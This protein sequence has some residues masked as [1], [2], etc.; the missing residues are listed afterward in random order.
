[1]ENLPHLILRQICEDVGNNFVVINLFLTCKKL[2][3]SVEIRKIHFEFSLQQSKR[4]SYSEYMK[5]EYWDSDIPFEFFIKQIYQLN[6]T[7]FWRSPCETTF[8]DDYDPLSVIWEIAIQECH[9]IRF[10]HKNRPVFK[11]C[12]YLKRKICQ[13]NSIYF[14]LSTKRIKLTDQV[15]GKFE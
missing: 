10:I 4:M 8:I 6:P 7:I 14:T 15:I 3:D 5:Q 1:M 13:D 11:G 2:Y 9:I 12:N